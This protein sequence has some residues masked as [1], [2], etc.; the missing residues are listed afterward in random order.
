M[1]EQPPLAVE[2]ALAR[3]LLLW[4]KT[5][6]FHWVSAPYLNPP[7]GDC[8]LWALPYWGLEMGMDC[9]RT[10]MLKAL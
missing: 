8:F 1:Q 5:S 3:E 7:L 6:F 4:F 2:D 9:C 10:L